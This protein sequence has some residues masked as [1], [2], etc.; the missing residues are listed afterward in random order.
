MYNNTKWFQ[1]HALLKRGGKKLE[2]F[3]NNV[4]KDIFVNA[5]AVQY[6][7]KGMGANKKY[8]FEDLQIKKCVYSLY[9]YYFFL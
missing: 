7:F 2:D 3:I 5:V 6:S 8:C 9:F 4:M 1:A